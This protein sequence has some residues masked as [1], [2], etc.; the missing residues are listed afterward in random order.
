MIELSGGLFLK[1]CIEMDINTNHLT[2]WIPI[3]EITDF[4]DSN[5]F[6]GVEIKREN[7]DWSYYLHNVTRNDLM[8]KLERWI[9]KDIDK[10]PPFI[11]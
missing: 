9:D 10:R 3:R 6:N 11:F 1:C 5:L 8:L 2:D 7:C 4:C